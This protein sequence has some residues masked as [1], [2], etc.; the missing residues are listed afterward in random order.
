MDKNFMIKYNRNDFY[1]IARWMLLP[2]IIVSAIFLVTFSVQFCNNWLFNNC[3]FGNIELGSHTCVVP[4]GYAVTI[5][6]FL[7]SFT[8]FYL[9][10]AVAIAL[11]V[12]AKK[13]VI[14]ATYFGVLY[15][16]F[17]IYYMFFDKTYFF[18]LAAVAITGYL[19]IKLIDSLIDS[20]FIEYSL[21]NSLLK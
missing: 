10:F 1:I 21:K 7:L 14:R 6:G 4:V 9:L 20:Y 12:T 16:M 18:A 3:T 15:L 8:V 5:E 17:T 13:N 11:P 19:S 2:F